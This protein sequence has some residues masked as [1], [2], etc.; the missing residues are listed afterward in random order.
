[1][2]KEFKYLDSHG[3]E[4]TIQLSDSSYFAFKLEFQ[5]HE[6][7]KD[8]LKSRDALSQVLKLSY[9]MDVS[10]AS[11]Q[12]DFKT[13]IREKDI[14]ITSLNKLNEV[15]TPLLNDGKDIANDGVEEVKN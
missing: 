12:M 1:M 8:L 9:A 4:R 10:E 13:W 11:D 3:N 2:I 14:P 15:L 6:T 5:F 7:L